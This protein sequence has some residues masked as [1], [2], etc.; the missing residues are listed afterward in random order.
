MHENNLHL[1]G[2]FSQNDFFFL[3]IRCDCMLQVADVAVASDETAYQF[4]K[5]NRGDQINSTAWEPEIVD[6][7]LQHSISATKQNLTAR[8][9]HTHTHPTENMGTKIREFFTGI[10]IVDT[11]IQPAIS[12]ISRRKLP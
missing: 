3:R 5:L 9:T 11:M 4:E 7:Q 10:G 8:D 6:I 1:N 12:A 2:Q